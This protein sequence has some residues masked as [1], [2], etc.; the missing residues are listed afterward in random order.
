MTEKQTHDEDD[1]IQSE[2]VRRAKLRLTPA[3][4]VAVGVTGVALAVGAVIGVDKGIDAIKNY[5]DAHLEETT[6]SAEA[7]KDM[8]DPTVSELRLAADVAIR[9]DGML[10]DTDTGDVQPNANLILDYK[11]SE[12]IVIQ[13][14]NGVY[15]RQDNNGNWYGFESSLLP[16]SLHETTAQNRL[17]LDKDGVVWVNSRD[18]SPVFSVVGDIA[19]PTEASAQSTDNPSDPTNLAGLNH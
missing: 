9:T 10:V 15:V 1:S 4:K 5:N 6:Y 16:A 7:L 17:N 3:G 8:L 12:P 11:S 2:A 13:T 19:T 18:A 14:P